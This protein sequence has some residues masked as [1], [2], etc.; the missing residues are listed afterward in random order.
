M[1]PSE[2]VLLRFWLKSSKGKSPGGSKPDLN[3]STTMAESWDT[4]F[5]KSGDISNKWN[6]L[7]LT[8]LPIPPLCLA[9]VHCLRTVFS[10]PPWLFYTPFVHWQLW[11]QTPFL[12]D[13]WRRWEWLSAPPQQSSGKSRPASPSDAHPCPADSVT[14]QEE[15]DWTPATG[16]MLHCL[17]EHLSLCCLTTCPSRKLF[18]WDSADTHSIY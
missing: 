17:H 2:P 9:P 16:Q 18:S 14:Q 5:R 12:L 13:I 15:M 3:D 6:E 7:L 8:L 1:V 11:R 4:R 10:L